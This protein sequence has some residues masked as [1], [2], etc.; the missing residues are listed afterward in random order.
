MS[1]II[2][3]QKTRPTFEKVLVMLG[4]VVA[5]VAINF[6]GSYFAEI[7]SLPLY[8]DVI[9]T[10][11]ASMLG[12]FIPGIMVGLIS[13]VITSLTVDPAAI[14]YAMLNVII[15]I[16]TTWFH[17]TGL[18]TKA[19]G[20]CASLFLDALIGGV[21]GGITTW[22]VYGSEAENSSSSVVHG[23]ITNAGMS[24][25]SAEIMGGF[26]VDI[27]DKTIC[28]SIA[29]AVVSFLPDSFKRIFKVHAW[30]QAPLT[31]EIVK[32]L[33]KRRSRQAS[34]RIKLVTLLTCA[35]VIVGAS[36]IY[37]CYH[38]YFS[39]NVDHQTQFGIGTSKLVASMVDADKIDEYMEKGH[40]LEEYVEV[41]NDL[42]RIRNCSDFAEY[43]YVYKILEDG[44]HVVFDIATGSQD[45]S[46]PGEVIAFD[47]SFAEYIP[48]LLEGGRI[49][50]IISN[51]KYGW[52]L[53]VYEPITDSR[54]N[55]VA[56]AG[57]DISMEQLRAESKSYIIRVMS[58]FIGI[59]ALTL[60]LGL[61][62]VEYQVI[63][64]LNTMAYTASMFS[65]KK[66]N[67]LAEI[68]DLFHQLHIY[69]GDETEN[70]YNAFSEMTDENLQYLIDIQKKNE[71]IG[72]MQDSLILVL[73]DM[74]E[75]RD[76]NTGDHVKKTAE[77]TEIIMDAMKKQHIYEDQLTDKFVNDVYRSAPL[78]DIGKISISDTILN[79]NGKLTD[80]EF[81]T[82][83]GHTTAGAEILDRVM[84][85]VPGSDSG[86]LQ[87]ARTMALYHHE[88]WNGKGYPT[89]ISGND[90]PLSARIMAVADVFD[91]LAS[92]RAYKKAF[93]F[94]K[95]IDIIKE[96]SGTHFDPLV[97][98]AFLSAEDRVRE[99]ASK[100]SMD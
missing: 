18:L 26:L 14:S 91:A 11:I 39:S 25:F 33:R 86:Y 10:L 56:Y 17:D 96:S 16:L 29:I 98:Q 67:S 47:D 83:K 3:H 15:A 73:A 94:E 43:I 85:K 57:V 97:A 34:L 100:K 89:G 36:A 44:C 68:A 30:K 87:E 74:V 40:E 19:Y 49:D 76:R 52:L 70:L 75:S 54:D 4:L 6:L 99:V 78:H 62:L 59:F 45:A 35:S 13:P 8:F 61:Y 9:G 53:T 2:R 64:P 90:I 21:L 51:D 72:N 27:A 66:N 7:T 38:M 50:P 46:S 41:E 24:P 37:I 22:F 42:R 60:A 65:E 12:G 81:E 32:E 5:G 48:T 23:L 92:D 88:K 28:L 93:P 69:T 80:E 63:L 20:F 71:M 82:M 79:K 31:S 77:Y 55:V 95:A 1:E 58:V 84:E